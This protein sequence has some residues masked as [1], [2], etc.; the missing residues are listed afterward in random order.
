MAVGIVSYILV[1]F[2]SEPILYRF[3]V[4][5]EVRLEAFWFGLT[6][7]PGFILLKCCQLEQIF[8]DE[9]NQE[10]VLWRLFMPVTCV[11]LTALLVMLKCFSDGLEAL[12]AYQIGMVFSLTLVVLYC[13]QLATLKCNIL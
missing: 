13:S 5:Q 1:L 2:F 6:A 9:K 10:V 7:F 11:L 8:V 4:A 12:Q 3:S